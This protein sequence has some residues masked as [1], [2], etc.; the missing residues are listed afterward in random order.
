MCISAGIAGGI[1]YYLGATIEQGVVGL[2]PHL[3]QAATPKAA[4]AARA[5][6]NIEVLGD[7]VKCDVRFQELKISPDEYQ[8]FK[9]KCMGDKYSDND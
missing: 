1:G 4:I 8:L 9:R 6:V 3:Q 2:P 5:D 7:R